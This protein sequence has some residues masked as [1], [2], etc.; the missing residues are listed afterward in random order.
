MGV[1]Y[2][3]FRAADDEAAKRVGTVLGGP[4]VARHP[5][6]VETKFVDP[7]VKIARLR[8]HVLGRPETHDL[9]S[10]TQLLPEAPVGPDNWGEPTLERLSDDLRDDLAGV[11]ENDGDELGRWWATTEEFVRDGADASFVASLCVDLLR[12]C[13]DARA[14]DEHVYVWSSL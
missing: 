12:L 8:F 6:V 4:A 1:T 3:Y 2:D 9:S 5:F 10:T 14:R 11:P 13:H 7:Y